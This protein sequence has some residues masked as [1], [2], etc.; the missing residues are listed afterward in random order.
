M[1]TGWMSNVQTGEKSSP[2]INNPRK[3][4]ALPSSY[5]EDKTWNRN[6]KRIRTLDP[7][8]EVQRKYIR[9]PPLWFSVGKNYQKRNEF[10][11]TL[12][13]YGFD[14]W[15]C[16]RHRKGENQMQ[17]RLYFSPRPSSST[18][19]ITGDPVECF[20]LRNRKSFAL[21][22]RWKSCANKSHLICVTIVMQNVTIPFPDWVSLVS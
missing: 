17:S 20:S 3:N 16:I 19:S 18:P 14:M 2:L 5:I 10:N 8:A 11:S 4:V 22:S 7:I 1:S 6:H 12:V 9:V 13:K 15:Y 21:N